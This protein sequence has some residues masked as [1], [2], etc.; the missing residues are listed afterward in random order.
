MI[1]S[2]EE[3]KVGTWIDGKPLYQIT[4]LTTTPTTNGGQINITDTLFNNGVIGNIVNAI[5]YIIELGRT[6]IINQNYNTDN[7]N[8]SNGIIFQNTDE[9]IK[10]YMSCGSTEIVNKPLYLT[11]QYTKQSDY[12]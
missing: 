10:I 7:L 12:E 9:G 8:V 11:I 5:G 4:F 1:Y 6:T 2:Y 3:R